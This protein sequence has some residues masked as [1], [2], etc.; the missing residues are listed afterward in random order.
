[1]EIRIDDI[2]Y[3]LKRDEIIIKNDQLYILNPVNL[4][5]IDQ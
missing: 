3:N 5:I 1:V 4:E 2:K